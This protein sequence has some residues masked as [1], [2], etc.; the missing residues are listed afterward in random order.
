MWKFS[1]LGIR[2]TDKEVALVG[3]IYGREILWDLQI[4]HTML[5]RRLH[6]TRLLQLGIGGAQ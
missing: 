3:G 5:V 1:M 4:V 2:K 6:G